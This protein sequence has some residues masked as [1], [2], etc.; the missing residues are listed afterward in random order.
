M[1]PEM[2]LTTF[3]LINKCQGDKFERRWRQ[4]GLKA[5][6][7]LFCRDLQTGRISSDVWKCQVGRREGMI[8]KDGSL[9]ETGDYEESKRVEIISTWH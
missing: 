4:K 2:T 1:S 8:L 7:G 5:D 3:F 6:S 9:H